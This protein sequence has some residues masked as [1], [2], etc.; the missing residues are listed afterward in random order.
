MKNLKVLGFFLY[1]SSLKRSFY[2]IMLLI[3]MLFFD[4]KVVWSQTMAYDI[5]SIVERTNDIIP[6]SPNAAALGEYVTQPVGYYTGIPHISIPIWN[7]QLKDFNLPISLDYHAG[8]ITVEET[9]SNVGLGWSLKAGGLITRTVRDIP[10]DEKSTNCNNTWYLVSGIDNNPP[11]VDGY[12]Y[13]ANG[14]L[15][16]KGVQSNNHFNGLGSYDVNLNGY[17]GGYGTST[18]SLN[19]LKKFYGVTKNQSGLFQDIFLLPVIDKEPDI[20]Y[21]N[22]ANYSGKFV[23]DVSGSTPQIRTIPYQDLKIEYATNSNKI[24]EFTITDP[25]GIKYIF[26]TI[27]NTEAHVNGNVDNISGDGPLGVDLE[28]KYYEPPSTVKNFTS[29]WYLSRVETPLGEWLD[30]EYVDETYRVD[31]RGP[32]N[33]TLGNNGGLSSPG[34]S[35]D[36]DP[37]V[38]SST[39]AVHGPS[40]GYYNAYSENYVIIFG[41][42]LSRIFNDEKQVVFGAGHERQD[43]DQIDPEKKAYA[44][45]AIVADTRIGGTQRIKSFLLDY[46]YF[47]SPI[48]NINPGGDFGSYFGGSVFFNFLDQTVNNTNALFNRLRLKSITEYGNN[49]ES[50]LPPYKFEYKDKDFTGVG[51]HSLPYRLSFQQ[52]YWGYYNAAS[53]NK[54][55]IPKL[56]VYP[57]HFSSKD[58]RQFSLYPRISYTGSQYTLKGAERRPNLNTFD[59][60]LLTKIIYPTGGFTN[61]E[62]SSHQFSYN[63][64]ERIGGGARIDRIIKHHGEGLQINYAEDII[65]DY[66]YTQSINNFNTSGVVIAPPIFA[67]RDKNIY[68]LNWPNDNGEIAYNLWTTRYSE[69]QGPLTQTSGSYIGYR[70]VLEYMSGAGYTE[71]KYSL[72]ASWYIANDLEIP[73]GLCDPSIDG[74]CDGFYNATQPVN[75]FVPW[76]YNTNNNT[77]N[78][79]LI[80]SN[81]DFSQFPTAINTFPFPE[82]PNYDW[83]RGHLL[84]EIQ[85]NESGDKV[86]ERTINY[87]NYFPNGGNA[88]KMIYGYRFSHH[89]PELNSGVING[90][91]D[92]TTD[93]K[94]YAF[95]AAK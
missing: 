60:G 21:F 83:Q 34:W 1:L 8:G 41:K 71:R 73:T 65:I 28:V 56:W 23:F 20:F 32:Q 7:L 16:A 54:T 6:P 44:I 78:Q 13:C 82:N 42:R 30:F 47:E 69:P 58:S 72:P 25:N 59:M 51:W 38:I 17:N 40:R 18:S 86:M 45:T 70:N 9:A 53:G 81:Y 3:L 61:F 67:Q 22:F 92:G 29:S 63:G 68:G 39:E 80:A 36:Y 2:C 95:R 50:E 66:Q 75:I 94:A 76:Y 35:I 19:L 88:P 55:L 64:E 48:E 49:L 74:H 43:V 77:T 93:P 90:S 14:L 5:N 79:E 33:T 52:D 31:S 24:S 37:N 15:W 89:Y 85:Y 11:L 91:N 27:E 10:D 12:S 87:K 62:Y 84:S 4:I 46:D 57:T 26:N